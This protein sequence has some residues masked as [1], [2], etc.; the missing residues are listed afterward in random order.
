MKKSI[1]NFNVGEPVAW[2]EDYNHVVGIVAEK[3]SEG[4]VVMATSLTFGAE[5]LDGVFLPNGYKVTKFLSPVPKVL[6]CVI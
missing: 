1:E 6:Q 2:L 3:D 5:C 4:V